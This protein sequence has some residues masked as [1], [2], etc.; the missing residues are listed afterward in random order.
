MNGLS[1]DENGFP[2]QRVLTGFPYE[3]VI[4]GLANAYH[5]GFYTG[6]RCCPLIKD[7]RLSFTGL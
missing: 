5:N 2:M 3:Q 7:T 6:N 1:S 4:Y